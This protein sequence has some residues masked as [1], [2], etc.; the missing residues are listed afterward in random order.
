MK[1]RD[2][3]TTSHGKIGSVSVLCEIHEH[4][5]ADIDISTAHNGS[6]SLLS[7]ANNLFYQPLNIY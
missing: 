7:V 3:E 6:T 1:W 5:N 4:I 2:T